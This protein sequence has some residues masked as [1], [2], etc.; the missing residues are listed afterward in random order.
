MTRRL[1]SVRNLFVFQAALFALIFPLRGGAQ[2]TNQF[3]S[4]PKAVLVAEWSEPSRD[5][6]SRNLSA[7]P[8]F[9]ANLNRGAA[10]PVGALVV[11]AKSP[12]RFA[13]LQPTELERQA[14][15]LINEQ[16]RL[17]NLTPLEWDLGMLYIARQHS[18]NMA[19]NHFFSHAGLDGKTTDER[20]DDAGIHDW[21]AIGENIAFN[22]GAQ[23]KPAFAV[24]CWLKSPKHKENLLDKKWTRAGVG[25]AVTDDGKFYATQ[26][27]RN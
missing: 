16:R 9:A 17:Q 1:F 27:F 6:E 5:A 11:S 15:D 21:R 10:A 25:V 12:A 13:S 20:A 19:K 23:N 24:E 4:K 22:Q 18:E 14:F 26:V 3:S 2:Q 7:R 8:R